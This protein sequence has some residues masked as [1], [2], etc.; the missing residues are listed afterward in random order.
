MSNILIGCA[1]WGYRPWVGPFLPAGTPAS[2]ML[3]AYSQ[4]LTTVEVNA[5]FYALPDAQTVARWAS[6]TPPGFRFCPKVPRIIS[7][8]GDLAPAQ[9]HTTAFIERMRGLGEKLGP[10][11]LQLPPAYSPHQL[12]DLAA[13]LRRW[14]ADLA[15]AVEVRHRGWFAS[16]PAAALNTLLTDLGMG[17]VLVDVR[18]INTG[19]ST[20]AVILEARRKKPTVPY[21]LDRTAPFTLIRFMGHPELAIDQPLLAQWADTVA[22]WAQQG[23][24]VYMFMH[25]PVE[26]QSPELCAIFAELLLARG[27]PTLLPTPADPQQLSLF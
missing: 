18:P 10:V 12:Q 13:W 1:I 20:D 9:E 6:D 22:A 2:A 26:E 11:F 17:R 3:A 21:H 27:L 24:T 23:T 14:P 19:A 15:L 7:H 5:T 25:C 16:Q 8:G 4:R